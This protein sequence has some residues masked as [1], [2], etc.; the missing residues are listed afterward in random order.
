MKELS[1]YL[2]DIAQNSIAAGCTRL[3]LTLTEDKL[4][5]LTMVVQDDG[6]GMSPALLARVK[7]PFVTSRSTRKVGLG[8]PLLTLA[9]Q[10]T[11]GEVTVEST[12][13]VGTTL[14][15]RFQLKNVD[16]PPMGDLAGTVALLVQGAETVELTLHRSTPEGGYTFS[17]RAIREILGAEIPLSSPE[18]F[19]W[20]REFLSQQEHELKEKEM[21]PLEN[22]GGTEGNS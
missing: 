6:R 15:A 18:V 12:Q 11:G 3:D 20:M 2:L 17:T 21:D 4:G 5:W 19:V 22:F 16:C 14:T 13:G 1:L 7:D 9:A 8:I 10:Q